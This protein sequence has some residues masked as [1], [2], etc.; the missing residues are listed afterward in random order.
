MAKHKIPDIE[1]QQG[2]V[3]VSVKTE[4]ITLNDKSESKGD[5]GRQQI[6]A[7]SQHLP[8]GTSIKDSGLDCVDSCEIFDI[9]Y[10][11]WENQQGEFVA[12]LA[13]VEGSKIRT[14]WI[15]FKSQNPRKTTESFFAEGKAFGPAV[16]ESLLGVKDSEL[17]LFDDEEAHLLFNL[18]TNLEPILELQDGGRTQNEAW[19]CTVWHHRDGQ[20]LPRSAKTFC[21]PVASAPAPRH[22]KESRRAIWRGKL[23]KEEDAATSKRLQFVALASKTVLLTIAPYDR[24]SLLENK[25]ISI[26]PSI[27]NEKREVELEGAEHIKQIVRVTTEHRQAYVFPFELCD[28]W[29]SFLAFV[30]KNCFK[31]L[32]SV[33]TT[34]FQFWRCR[35]Q[36]TG[37]SGGG[38]YDPNDTV[39]EKNW[40]KKASKDKLIVLDLLLVV[41]NDDLQ[42][43]VLDQTTE[44]KRH[45]MFEPR[46]EK[47]KTYEVLKDTVSWMRIAKHHSSFL[48]ML[49]EGSPRGRG[50]T[51]KSPETSSY[52]PDWTGV[53][54]RLLEAIATKVALSMIQAQQNNNLPQQTS[55][56]ESSG[57][58]DAEVGSEREA[59]NLR[60]PFGRIKYEPPKS[61]E[62]FTPK[63]VVQTMPVRGL[64]I[65]P[66]LS[67]NTLGA[68]E[69]SGRSSDSSEA[70]VPRITIF[71]LPIGIGFLDVIISAK[72]NSRPRA[73][74]RHGR[75]DGKSVAGPQKDSLALSVD[76]TVDNLMALTISTSSAV[77][78]AL[79]LSDMPPDEP[80]LDE[81]A[82][83][84]EEYWDPGAFQLFKK[85]VLSGRDLEKDAKE[86][87]SYI[88][89]TGSALGDGEIGAPMNFSFQNILR[90]LDCL[91]GFFFG[92]L[93][94]AR[95]HRSSWNMTARLYWQSVLRIKCAI[96]KVPAFRVNWQRTFDV[97]LALVT[98]AESI[99]DGCRRIDNSEG[100]ECFFVLPRTFL[101]LFALLTFSLWYKQKCLMQKFR[102]YAHSAP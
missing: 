32:E 31:D 56:G 59:F 17:H 75:Q 40:M 47:P 92:G 101:N 82:S 95:E 99:Q 27:P 9:S 96:E 44:R 85:T 45:I 23:D 63:D 42:E 68:S 98:E 30:L 10:S 4:P 55:Q 77:M 5:P 13:N 21:M 39:N 29:F 71:N 86:V 90:F 64:N 49:E 6:Q 24:K 12:K 22:T 87:R 94:E 43:G 53:N 26:V 97:L 58:E 1:K 81:E 91:F 46:I 61:E 25:G 18:Q 52:G 83:I 8:D 33:G 72:W 76:E 100:K 16:L 65:M 19:D 34:D 67:Y 88:K 11:Q 78:K 69:S 38:S 80:G 28:T 41:Q 57:F 20:S 60:T 89:P 79:T 102:H 93:D 7:S 37:S 73:S 35:G 66:T 51:K 70:S 48:P 14:R 50:D 54:D 15:H 2:S 62:D 36:V 3:A 74:R 84:Y